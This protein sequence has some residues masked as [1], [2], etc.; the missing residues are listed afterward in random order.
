VKIGVR[1]PLSRRFRQKIPLKPLFF[2]VDRIVVPA[3]IP[4]SNLFIYEFNP[5][6][7]KLEDVFYVNNNENYDST[8]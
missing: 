5:N 1:L 2:E 7:E 6:G 3:I 8:G 4:H